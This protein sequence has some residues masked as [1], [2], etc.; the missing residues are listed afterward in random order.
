[1]DLQT[2][3]RD[4]NAFRSRAAV[5]LC[6]GFRGSGS[7]IWRTDSIL[8]LVSESNMAIFSRALANYLCSVPHRKTEWLTLREHSKIPSSRNTKTCVSLHFAA[9]FF[10]VRTYQTDYN[11]LIIIESDGFN[12]TLAPFNTCPN[13]NGPIGNLGNT[14]A[15]QWFE[16]Y[17]QP[18]VKRLGAMVQ[19]VNLT[20][21][22]VFEMQLTC[23]YEVR[24]GCRNI[25]SSA[26]AI[27]DG[28]A[29]VLRILWFVYRRRMGRFRVCNCMSS[30]AGTTTE[31]HLN[32]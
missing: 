17:L 8:V 5:S 6:T 25:V 16:V 27:S 29:R 11:Q 9:G 15:E 13:S 2:W 10:G 24:S 21:V 32:I 22:D 12:N 14:F 7:R 3:S 23:A 26:D 1:M 28:R 20:V 4:F 19:G 18:A 30:D 31:T